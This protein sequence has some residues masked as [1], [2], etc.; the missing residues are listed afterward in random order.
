MIRLILGLLATA[1]AAPAAAQEARTARFQVT[2]VEIALPIPN[3]FCEPE[4]KGVALAQLL[5]AGDNVNVTNLTL[6]RCGAEPRLVDYYLLKTTKS[7]LTLTVSREQWIAMLVESLDDP[8]VKSMLDPAKINAEA[9]RDIMAVIGKVSV[10]GDVH[11]LGHDDVCVYLGGVIRYE[12]ETVE[13][14]RAMTGCMTAVGGRAVNLYRY[15]AGETANVTRYL[16]DI[17]A[18][19][20]SMQGGPAY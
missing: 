19:A 10:D 1:A 3:G 14:T 8:S 16:A 7:L 13:E 6:T 17:K 11:W 15:S 4:G 12:I 9:E 5:A 2:G 18:M 20:L